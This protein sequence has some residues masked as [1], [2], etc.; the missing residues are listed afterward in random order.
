MAITDGQGLP[1]ALHVASHSPHKVNL[2]GEPPDGRFLVTF[3]KRLIGDKAYDGD[4]LD[5]EQGAKGIEMIA[6]HRRGRKTPKLWK[7]GH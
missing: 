3:P 2:V 6:P 7:E 5:A 4:P 1:V